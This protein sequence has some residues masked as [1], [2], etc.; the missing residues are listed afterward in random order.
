MFITA[1]PTFGFF[2]RPR[3]FPEIFHLRFSLLTVKQSV[4]NMSL[5][6]KLNIGH[7]RLVQ[8]GWYSWTL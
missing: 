7:T 4:L 6:S 2:L 3:Y 1:N 5:P 8:R